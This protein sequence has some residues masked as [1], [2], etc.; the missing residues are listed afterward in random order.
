MHWMPWASSQKVHEVLKHPVDGCEMRRHFS[1]DN[2]NGP[3]ILV[4]AGFVN[5]GVHSI[6]IAYALQHSRQWLELP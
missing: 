1:Q 5:E 6:D 2:S 3:D 4:R